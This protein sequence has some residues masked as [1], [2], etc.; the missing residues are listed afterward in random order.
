MRTLA[1]CCFGLVVFASRSLADL[2]NLG[3]QWFARLQ[4][5]ETRVE[6]LWE[7]EQKQEYPKTRERFLAGGPVWFFECPQKAHPGAYLVLRDGDFHREW[8]RQFGREPEI[9]PKHVEELRRE[10][11]WRK[12]MAEREESGLVWKPGEPWLSSA[13]GFLINDSG[14]QLAP[15]F[16]IGAGVIADFEGDGFVD[17]FDVG[18]CHLDGN[19]VLDGLSIGPLDETKPRTHLYHCNFSNHWMERKRSWRFRIVSE[20]PAKVGLRFSPRG[21]GED[22]VYSGKSFEGRQK[23]IHYFGNPKGLSM[24]EI[25]QFRKSIGKFKGRG[26]DDAHE[27]DAESKTPEAVEPMENPFSVPDL[28]GLSPRE[29]AMAMVKGNQDSVHRKH[30]DLFPEGKPLALPES[31]WL[32]ISND[33]GGWYPD[34]VTVWWLKDEVAECWIYGGDMKN[35]QLKKSVVPKEEVRWMMASVGELDRIRSVPTHPMVRKKRIRGSHFGDVP[36]DKVRM[37]SG[38]EI[39][40]RW[41]FERD[42]AW[43]WTR[44]DGSY[45]RKLAG[46][47][48]G[49]M[50]RTLSK[51]EEEGFVGWKKVGAEWLA[52]DAYENVPPVLLQG[53]LDRCEKLKWREFKPQLLSLREKLI[54][55]EDSLSKIKRLEEIQRVM[56]DWMSEGELKKVRFSLLRQERGLKESLVGDP[57]FELLEALEKALKQLN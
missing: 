49:M 54:V 36:M 10:R 18:R 39:D 27:L 15:K 32:E 37:R 25:S 38:G 41:D 31:G 19:K 21:G 7:W 28:A 8:E 42:L 46:L 57:R 53:F 5:S 52:D 20:G 55:Q 44:M 34:Y 23:T 13:T 26:T 11:E 30:F 24:E 51:G 50:V 45:S 9:Y 2:P 4:N 22:V 56:P 3:P 29:A 33:C 6:A 1:I 14:Q 12:E 40:S 16:W 17:L 43:E 48:A 35:L 47:F